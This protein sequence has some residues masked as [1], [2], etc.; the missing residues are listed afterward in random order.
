MG[1]MHIGTVAA[2]TQPA[3]VQARQGPRTERGKF[4][5]VTKKLSTI[6]TFLPKKNY[7]FTKRLTVYINHTSRQA[8]HAGIVV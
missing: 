4:P 3:Q 8:P 7:Y 2:H 6:D 1:L 5:S